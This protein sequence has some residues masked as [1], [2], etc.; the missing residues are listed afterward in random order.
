MFLLFL[1]YLVNN[2]NQAYDL[3]KIMALGTNIMTHFLFKTIDYV[4][5]RSLALALESLEPS[6]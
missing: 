6:T 3:W 5:E 1:N 4:R 2:I